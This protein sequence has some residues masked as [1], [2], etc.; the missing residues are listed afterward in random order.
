M[1]VTGVVLAPGRGA[2]ATGPSPGATGPVS[3]IQQ[4]DLGVLQRQVPYQLAPVA[5]LLQGQWP[6]QTSGLPE[7]ASLPELDE[8]PHLSYAI[9]WFAFAGIA[10]VGYVLLFQRDRRARE[11]HAPEEGGS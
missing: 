5:L 7:P 3:V 4:V 8:G 11:R 1:T 9:Q 2:V 6:S 10:V